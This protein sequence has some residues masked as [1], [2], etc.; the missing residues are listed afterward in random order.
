MGHNGQNDV[1]E[2]G[3]SEGDNAASWKMSSSDSL[4][5][6][7]RGIIGD[8]ALSQISPAFHCVMKAG[9]GGVGVWGA[10]EVNREKRCSELRCSF[11]QLFQTQVCLFTY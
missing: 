7:E 3:N 2:S 9:G 1:Q 6:F 5:H 4:I 10:A 11:K 8:S